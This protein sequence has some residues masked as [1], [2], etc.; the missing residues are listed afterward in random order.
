MCMCIIIFPSSHI[1]TTYSPKTIT[2]QK[3]SEAET[4]DRALQQRVRRLHTRLEKGIVNADTMVDIEKEFTQDH[5]PLALKACKF[6]TK[7]TDPFLA[8]KSC[9]DA[10]DGSGFVKL[11]KREPF[12]GK[13]VPGKEIFLHHI[14]RFGIVYYMYLQL[15]FSSCVGGSYYY[16]I[17]HST[18]VAFTVGAKYKP[19]NGFKIIGG[20]TGK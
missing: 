8:V 7:S 11:S 17:N 13:L 18:I 3:H 19:G 12:G 1:L 14:E 2:M 20:H 4:K 9:S 6:L 5:T 15:L 16:T 10:L